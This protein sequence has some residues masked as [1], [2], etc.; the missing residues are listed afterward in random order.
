ML[1][2]FPPFYDDD[3]E[4]LFEKILNA[5]YTFPKPY[6]NGISDSAKDLISRLLVVDTKKR[7]DADGILKHPWVVGDKTPRT[8]LKLVSKEMKRRRPKKK[9]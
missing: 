7:L 6:W 2:G 9:K 8:H 1:C 5:E 3:N 4:A